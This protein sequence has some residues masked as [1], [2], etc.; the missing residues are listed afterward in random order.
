MLLLGLRVGAH[1]AED[2]VGMLRQGRPGLLSVDDIMFAVALGRSAQRR[3]VG[4]GARLGKALTPPIVEVGDARQ[5]ML[6]LLFGAEGDHHRPDHRDP[7]AE[8]LRRRGQ[9]QLFLEHVLLD[10]GPAGAAP[11]DR[12][13]GHRPPLGIEDALPSDNV[14]LG[15]AF[16][17]DELV[18]NA[19]G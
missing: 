10:R 6:L 16:V 7:E 3:K 17:G 8:R 18:A 13:I 5:K 2:P 12:P 15:E 9:L 19:L 4:A 1:Q 14:V 11:F